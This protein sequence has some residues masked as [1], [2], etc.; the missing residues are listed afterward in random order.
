MP[1]VTEWKREL[2]NIKSL[3]VKL[4]SHFSIHT[5]SSDCCCVVSDQLTIQKTCIIMYMYIHVLMRDEKEG[6]KKQARSNKQTRQSNTAHPRQSLYLKMSCLGWDSNPR[7]STQALYTKH[8]SYSGISAHAMHAEGVHAMHAEGVH[9]QCMPKVYMQCM[10][11]VY[12]HNACRRCTCN[13]CRRCTCTMH[14]EGVHAMHAEGVHAQC[15]P[16]VYM[17]CMPKVYMHNACR[18]CTCT[19][20]AE[21]V[22]AQ[23]MPKVYMHNACRRCTCTMHAKGVHAQCT[24]MYKTDQLGKT[25]CTY[26]LNTGVHVSDK[27]YLLFGAKG[28]VVHRVSVP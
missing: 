11:K 7:H 17:Q 14:A 8:V 27:A 18:R 22:H 5:D 10:P 20:H 15:M 16:K 6:R 19:M 12:M 9:A 4:Y 25:K 3:V 23:C 21:G 2:I 28:V 13:A 24:C 26:I 1:F